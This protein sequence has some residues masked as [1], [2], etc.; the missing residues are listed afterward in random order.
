MLP[1]TGKDR[2]VHF[3][4]FNVRDVL[5]VLIISGQ[6]NMGTELYIVEEGR[7]THTQFRKAIKINKKNKQ[8]NKNP[9]SCILM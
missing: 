5:F 6:L 2:Q 7:Y 3:I 9:S 1:S 8:T 4:Y